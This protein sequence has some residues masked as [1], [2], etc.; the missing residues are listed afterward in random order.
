[1]ALFLSNGSG[2]STGGAQRGYGFSV[3]CIKDTNYPGSIG[4]L[5]CFGASINGTLTDGV[6][7]S[8]VSA[9]ISYTNGN[10]A[11]HTGQTVLSSGVSGLTATL[12]AGTFA[13]GAGSL[14]YTITGTPATDGTAEFALNIGGQNCTL[15]IPVASA[16]FTCGTSTVTF[17]Y[18]G[19]PV[20]YG[21]VVGAGNRCW[22][23]RNL[24]ASQVAT[25]STDAAAYGDLFQWGRGAD[26]H[27][28]RN[29]LSG[30]TST[31]S[32]TDSP[33]HGNFITVN[34]SPWDWRSP[35]NTNLWQGVTG[36]NNP[37]PSGY[38]VPTSAELD[39]EWLSWGGNNNALG[40]INS[41]LK[42]PLAGF[43]YRDNGSLL[44]VGFFVNYWSSTGGVG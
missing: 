15:S 31:L 32:N 2:V 12:T 19:S 38:R 5:D 36:I 34:T 24:G 29:P 30:T 3:R 39:I 43:R 21:T 10:G 9:D 14:T 37:C 8:G 44:D 28:V 16:S 22:L 13:S 18:R 27:Q 6:A 25:S 4:S 23:D 20:T 11:T 1:M 7:V 40:A 35:Q 42:L 26:G 17:T 33:G 41:P